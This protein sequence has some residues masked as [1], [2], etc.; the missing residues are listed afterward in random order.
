LAAAAAIE[1]LPD[2]MAKDNAVKAILRFMF[3]S[4]V[5]CRF[6]RGAAVRNTLAAL[7]T[8][9]PRDKVPPGARNQQAKSPYPG[10]K[11]FISN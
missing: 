6:F 4:S 7:P 5:C 9:T 8:S 2:T 11:K 10:S 1:A 3:V